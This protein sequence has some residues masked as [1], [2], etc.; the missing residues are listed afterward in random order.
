MFLFKASFNFS[1]DL[2]VI[3]AFLAACN[4]AIR[5][6]VFK[7]GPSDICGRQPL[8]N[9]GCLPQILLGPFLNI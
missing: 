8:K 9:E 2:E 3:N 6:K 4:Y 5:D 7:I 1:D